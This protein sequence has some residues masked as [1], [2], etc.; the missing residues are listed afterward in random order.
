MA[1][2]ALVV[3]EI[4]GMGRKGVE[5]AI[6]VKRPQAR[7]KEK[8]FSKSTLAM[9]P[10]RRCNSMPFGGSSL[11]RAIDDFLISTGS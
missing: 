10:G 2:F 5:R 7:Q 9:W 4:L 8:I 11:R 1:S 6:S 3:K